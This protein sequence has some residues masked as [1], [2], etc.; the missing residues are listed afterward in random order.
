MYLR[1]GAFNEISAF[2]KEILLFWKMHSPK[3]AWNKPCIQPT[4]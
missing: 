2:L 1:L 4:M 3:Y